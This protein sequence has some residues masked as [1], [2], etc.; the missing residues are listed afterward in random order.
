[1]CGIGRSEERY[2][3]LISDIRMKVWARGLEDAQ[4]K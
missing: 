4:Q 2:H 3:V 1:M